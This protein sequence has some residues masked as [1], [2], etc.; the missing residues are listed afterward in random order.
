MSLGTGIEFVAA[1]SLIAGSAG[2]VIATGF[3][4]LGEA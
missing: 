4:W 1:S 2:V 3:A